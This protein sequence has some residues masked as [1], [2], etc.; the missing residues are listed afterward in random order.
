MIAHVSIKLDILEMDRTMAEQHR[1]V[2]CLI[3]LLGWISKLVLRFALRLAV[4]GLLDPT[5]TG[6]DYLSTA[7]PS[8]G[9][10]SLAGQTIA[11]TTIG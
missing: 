1:E 5:A 3:C 7:A 10:T 6:R 4:S 11:H 9:H 8:C 2:G